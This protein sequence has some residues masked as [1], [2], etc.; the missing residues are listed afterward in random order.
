MTGSPEA[1][2]SGAALSEPTVAATQRY[3]AAPVVSSLVSAALTW[4]LPARPL[5]PL[6]RIAPKPPCEPAAPGLDWPACP[7]P[8]RPAPARPDG[9]VPPAGPAT[10][11]PDRARDPEPGWPGAN[12]P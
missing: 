12:P 7:A 2:W 5:G 11:G 1:S 3:P 4:V 6:P 8:A 10:P 9:S